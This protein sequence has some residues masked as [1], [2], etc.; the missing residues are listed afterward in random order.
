MPRCN[1]G[2]YLPR[3]SSFAIISLALKAHEISCNMW[4]TRK[5]FPITQHRAMTTIYEPTKLV[6]PS[7]F[8]Y[9]WKRGS[10]EKKLVIL[11]I[12][13]VKWKLVAWVT[14]WIPMLWCCYWLNIELFPF[15]YFKSKYFILVADNEYQYQNCSGCLIL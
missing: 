5:I 8:W 7:H 1:I 12:I 4:E 11:Y 9:D 15:R 2:K 6:T 13:G 10:F 3:F 14:E